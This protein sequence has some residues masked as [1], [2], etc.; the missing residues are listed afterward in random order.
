VSE[1]ISDDRLLV[2]FH[3]SRPAQTDHSF[4][5]ISLQGSV[6]DPALFA[7]TLAGTALDGR[8]GLV[9]LGRPQSNP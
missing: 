7:L 5:I 8:G 4:K 3:P 2:A 9:F 6:T 1:N